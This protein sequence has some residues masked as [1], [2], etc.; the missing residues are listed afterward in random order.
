M[1][2]SHITEE[3]KLGIQY[4]RCFQKRFGNYKLGGFAV[5]TLFEIFWKMLMVGKAK[6]VHIKN[7]I[8]DSGISIRLGAEPLFLFSID[9]IL[10]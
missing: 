7:E 1:P 3:R 8:L 4:Q 5:G 6:A 9:E 10:L 2:T